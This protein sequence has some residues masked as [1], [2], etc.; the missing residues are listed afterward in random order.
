MI[1]PPCPLCARPM[2]ACTCGST[3]ARDETPLPPLPSRFVKRG[4]YM[5]CVKC[6]LTVDYCK[7][8]PP[9]DAQSKDGADSSLVAR[10]RECLGGR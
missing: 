5:C 3:P 9:P 4:F 2:P 6:G 1:P 8:H 10:I 7:G